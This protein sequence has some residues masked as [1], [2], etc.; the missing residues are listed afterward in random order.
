MAEK[1]I[2]VLLTKSIMDA[3]DRGVRYVAMELKDSGME[4]ICTR[5]GVPQEIVNTAMQE[6]ADVIGISF[7]SGAP[8][9]IISEVLRLLKKNKMGHMP[10]IVGGVIPDDEVSELLKAG[11]KGVF[12]PGSYAKDIIAT[13]R[14]QSQKSPK[15]SRGV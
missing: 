3:H 4:V 15:G 12:G 11:V 8:K 14:A 5:Y 6:D 10:V 9:I 1:K 13:I 7:S 2:R